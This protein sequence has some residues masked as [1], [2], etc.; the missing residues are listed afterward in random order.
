[1]KNKKIEQIFVFFVIFVLFITNAYSITLSDQGTDVKLN[2]GSTL[3]FGNLSVKI[4]DNDTSGS[5]IF[6]QNFTNAII[7]GS[8]NVMLTNVNLEYGKDYYKDYIINGDDLSFD[9][10]DRIMF[11]SPLG[12]IS[13]EDIL[14]NSIYDIDVYNLSYSKIQSCFDNG[15]LKYVDGNWSCANET[16]TQWNITTS[17]YLV[18]NS[19][20]LEINETKFNATIDA[21]SAN[22]D[23][24]RSDADILLVASVYNETDLIDS[25]YNLSLSDVSNNLG[26]WSLDKSKYYNT[27]QVDD[28]ADSI[29]TSWKTNATSQSNLINSII[30][31]NVS[32]NES[33]ANTL[34]LNKTDQTYNETSLIISVNA[35]WKS[36][37]SDQLLLI[38]SMDNLSLSDVATNLGNWSANYSDY[39]RNDGD[40][41]T[42]D[43]TF[44][45]SLNVTGNLTL[46]AGTIWYNDSDNKYYYYNTSA[47][48]ELGSDASSSSI[49]TS[50]NITTSNYLINSSGVLELNETKLNNTI[51]VRNTGNNLWTNNSGVASYV[52]NANVSGNLTL[53]A[54]TIRWNDTE[55]IYYN[56]STWQS[57]GSSSTS[58]SGTV[59]KQYYA[60][61]SDGPGNFNITN[62][63]TGTWTT[64]RGIAIPYQTS[65]GAWRLRFNI[66]GTAEISS[67][68]V[69]RIKIAGVIFKNITNYDQ[70]VTVSNSAL[71]TFAAEEYFIAIANDG[72]NEIVLVLPK[73]V[74]YTNTWGFSGDVELDS[75]PSWADDSVETTSYW[76]KTGNDTYY[77]SGNVNI[78]NNLTVDGSFNLGNGTIQYNDSDNKY[79]YYNTSSWQELGSG[80]SSSTTDT[81]WN[82]TTSN[83]LTNISGILSINETLLNQTINALEN[84]TTYTHL[85][86]FT[87]NINATNIWKNVSGIVTYD[88]SVNITGNITLG[89]GVMKYNNTSN[90]FMYHNGSIWQDLS[91]VNYL[92][93]SV[94]ANAIMAFNQPTCPDGWI[95]AD[96]TSGTPDLRGIFVR[97][98]GTNEQISPANNTNY[99]YT[100]IYGNYYNDSLQGHQHHLL[101]HTSN[102]GDDDATNTNYLAN[103]ASDGSNFWTSSGPNGNTVSIGNPIT[104]ETN[105]IP[106]IGPETAP[107]SYA[108]IYCMKVD[109]ERT[110]NNLFTRIGNVISLFNSSNALNINSS[111]NITGNLNLGNGTIWYN[112]SDNKYYYYNTTAWQVIGSGASS[113][114]TPGWNITTSNYL[115]NN[116]GVLEINETLF[117]QTINALE[118]DTIYTADES[119]I[120]L[121]S[122]NSFVLNETVL[123]NTIESYGYIKNNSYVNFSNLKTTTLNITGN[124]TLG[125]G[126]IKWNNTEF[127]YYNGSAWQSLGSGTTSYSGTVLK[128]YVGGNT[129]AGDDFNVTGDNG[130]QTYL[131]TAIPYKTS[132]GSWRIR[133]NVWGDV[134]TSTPNVTLTFEGVTFKSTD[135]QAITAYNDR[136]DYMTTLAIVIAGTGNMISFSSTGSASDRG[137]SGDVE[138]DSKPTWADDPTETVSYWSKIGNDTYY[139]SGNVNITNNLTVDGSL[140]LGN[141]TIRYNDSDN[142]YYYYNTS[143]WQELGSGASSDNVSWNESYA[144]TLYLNKTDQRYNE[145]TLIVSVNASWKT[146][147]SDQLVLINSMDNLSL[148]D[149]SDNIGNWSANYSDYMRNDGDTATG[150]YTFNNTL[151]H[152]DTTHDRIGIG[153]TSPTHA[154]NVIGDVNITGDLYVNASTIYIG[155]TSLSNVNGTITWGGVSLGS[156]TP[157]N[158]IMAFNQPT[159]PDGWTLADG[160]DGTPDLR[161]IFVRGAGANEQIFP[162]NNTNYNYTVIYGNY[163]NDSFQGHKHFFLFKTGDAGDQ[164]GNSGTVIGDTASDASFIW[165]GNSGANGNTVSIGNPLTDGTNGNPRT[166]YE[167]APASYAL[168]YCMKTGE[169]STNSNSLWQ[170]VNNKVQLANTSKIVE[171]NNLNVTGNVSVGQKLTFAFGEAIDNVVDGWIKISGSLNVTGNIDVTNNLTV[172]GNIVATGNG[173]GISQ[174]VSKISDY[175]ITINDRNV[176]IVLNSSA[177]NDTTFRLPSVDSSDNGVVYRIL[178]DA[179]YV[180]TIT[181]NDTS[182]VWNSGS[183]YGIDLPDKGTMVKLRYSSSRNKWDILQKTGGKVL[184]EGLVLH[185]DMSRAFPIQAEGATNAMSLDLSK[186]HIGSTIGAIAQL[187]LPS[188]SHFALGGWSFDGSSYFLYEYNSSD[189]DIF[190]TNETRHKTVAGWVYVTDASGNDVIFSQSNSTYDVDNRIKFYVG[191]YKIKL[192]GKWDGTTYIAD[193]NG[194]SISNKTWYHVALIID[195]ASTGVYVDGDQI[196]WNESFVPIAAGG[197]TG[198]LNI[199]VENGNDYL[200]GRMQ[201]LHISYNNPYNANPNSESTDNFTLPAAPFVGVMT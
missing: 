97:G 101:F 162:A 136:T 118:N 99:N 137:F 62:G 54:G 22:S 195:G 144:N 182:S 24:N 124:L 127:I 173:V 176:L 194:G 102:I 141:G 49:D 1:M 100:A 15:I 192:Y 187:G 94:P 16:K 131:A 163:Y 139:S 103:I 59:L 27:T 160:T 111:V 64:I 40:S 51:D 145:T 66:V 148:S 19:G 177:T 13:S 89:K 119:Y 115:I 126:T 151:L 20:V 69:Y 6:S 53:G 12:V 57:L 63:S 152:I 113:S 198:G 34:Y 91:Y 58:S 190:G 44:N 138:L 45:G 83:Y 104:D 72:T 201:D 116:S 183:G 135:S 23:T 7:N 68:N 42:G 130:W 154:L 158:A 175:N 106:R 156:S 164:D 174:D 21:R 105:G 170:G 184:I 123:N 79:Y 125:A 159:C 166:S 41:A 168:I 71:T 107:A 200:D 85:S 31:D 90:T 11:T 65:D 129:S 185:E 169:D 140:N 199:G 43:Y 92:N 179:S 61:S 47:W 3:E 120:N 98:A 73:A 60:N 181:P 17:Y 32:W 128:Q 82:I 133:F 193:L 2:N 76:S 74:T 9:S 88:G 10:N 191:D 117:N 172:T 155:N 25:M 157:V 35:S 147:A 161:G 37:A 4:Y 110:E 188:Q 122:S 67:L 75:K 84:D 150:N 39:M 77:S 56:G 52:G 142:K 70:A 18:N 55:F 189:W 8:W 36:N 5:L 197:F 28:I 48:Q 81:S 14:D 46:G 30:G 171:V 95:L 149:I 180:L 153:T 121:N 165:T 93:S 132:D 86:N 134:G 112:N 29:N 143:S 96:G 78:T 80:A 50:W 196:I 38:N 87:D 108:L 109:T 178:N 33:Y 146:N 26:N 167:T 114:T 186:R